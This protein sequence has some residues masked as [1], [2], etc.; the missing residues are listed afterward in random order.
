MQLTKSET[1]IARELKKI[2]SGKAMPAPI[3]ISTRRAELQGQKVQLMKAIGNA[4]K[5]RRL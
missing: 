1:E 3:P 4:G 2:A 5:P